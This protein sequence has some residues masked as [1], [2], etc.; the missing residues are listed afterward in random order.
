[1]DKRGLSGVVTTL[2]IVLITV[3][4]VFILAS[5]MVPWVQNTLDNQKGCFNI[6]G[7]LKFNEAKSCYNI[8]DGGNINSTKINI[9]FGKSNLSEIILWL[10]INGDYKMYRLKRGSTCCNSDTPPVTIVNTTGGTVMGM[11]KQ[12]SEMYYI[13]KDKVVKRVKVAPVVE[14]KDCTDIIEDMELERCEG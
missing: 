8:S 13:I 4:A 3:M 2:L 5:V 1:M 7:E 9:V 11:G 6:R 10:D 14:G 12:G